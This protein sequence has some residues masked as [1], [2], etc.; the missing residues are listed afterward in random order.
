M[1][2]I[3]LKELSLVPVIVYLASLNCRIDQH[4]GNL[5]FCHL[6]YKD[7]CLH[8]CQTLNLPLTWSGD[9]KPL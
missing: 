6:D 4:P 8:I 5:G 2:E 9:F 3:H 7:G 1:T